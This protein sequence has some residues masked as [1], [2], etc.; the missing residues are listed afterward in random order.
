MKAIT[1]LSNIRL[2]TI[3]FHDQAPK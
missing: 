3:S 2:Y 1:T